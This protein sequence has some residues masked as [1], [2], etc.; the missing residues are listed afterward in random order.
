MV[1]VPL[2]EPKSTSE[3][4]KIGQVAEQS[5]LP[6]KTIRYYEEIGLLSPTVERSEAG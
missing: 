3:R 1:Q 2:T 5:G 4:F 6:V